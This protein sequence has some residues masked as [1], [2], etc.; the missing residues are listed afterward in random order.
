MMTNTAAIAHRNFHAA[1]AA[2][3]HQDGAPFM[4]MHKVVS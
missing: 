4:G 3:I 1:T 2:V